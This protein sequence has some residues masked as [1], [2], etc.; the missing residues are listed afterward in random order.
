MC[1][2]LDHPNII[3]QIEYGTGQYRKNGKIKRHCNYIVLEIAQGGELFD[4]IAKSGPL[5]EDEARYFFCQL[6][7]GLNYCHNYVKISHR[8]LKPENLL[9]SESFD[10]KIADFGFA[11]PVEGRDGKGFLHTTLGTLGYMAPEILLQVPYVGRE[12]DLFAAA[13]ILFV[14]VVGH[15]PFTQASNE[16]RLY[17]MIC[18]NRSDLFWKAHSKSRG[19]GNKLMSDELMN[20]LI[21]MFQLEPE[22]RPS[23]FEVMAHP[24]MQ[25]KLP[26]K[27]VMLKSMTQRD[28]M[29]KQALEQGA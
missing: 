14:L 2:Q 12:I 7:D 1:S 23:L 27:K 10:L 17:M 20:L 26:D 4:F 25:T 6:L 18:Q 11:A 3:R 5:S 19:A 8:D 16:D 28:Q 29:I 9:L 15:P 21:C 13:V 22:H 24:W